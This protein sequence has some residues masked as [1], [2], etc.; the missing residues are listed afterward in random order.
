MTS[1]LKVDDKPF[2]VLTDTGLFPCMDG[3]EFMCNEAVNIR[4]Y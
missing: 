4:T 1:P 3:G 2:N